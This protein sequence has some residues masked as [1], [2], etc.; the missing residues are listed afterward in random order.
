MTTCD[1]AGRPQLILRSARRTFALRLDGPTRIGRT[2]AADVQVPHASVSTWHAEL[3]DLVIGG[4]VAGA[5]LGDA[6]SKWELCGAGEADTKGGDTVREPPVAILRDLGSMNGTFADGE[7]Q[8][9]TRVPPEGALLRLGDY[10]RFGFCPHI[11]RLETAFYEEPSVPDN[12]LTC[13]G[14][15]GR[16]DL[17]RQML[18]TAEENYFAWLTQVRDEYISSRELI[19][20][21]GESRIA[22]CPSLQQLQETCQSFFPRPLSRCTSGASR[23]GAGAFRPGSVLGPP[24]RDE[25]EEEDEDEEEEKGDDHSGKAKQRHP[26]ATEIEQEVERLS[27]RSWEVVSV[28]RQTINSEADLV[29]LRQNLQRAHRFVTEELPSAALACGVGVIGLVFQALLARSG[30]PTPGH[31]MRDRISAVDLGVVPHADSLITGAVDLCGLLRVKIEDDADLALA[32][33][34]LEDSAQFLD[35]LTQCARWRG[36]TDWELFAECNDA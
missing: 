7:R 25:S 10:I 13:A 18:Q 15:D 28:M 26:P 19:G 16:M 3:E 22:D 6:G 17:R 32:R 23:T 11:H 5:D 4:G 12:A 35:D 21:A 8:P 1:Q 31:A 20:A 30:R 33:T 34:V 14:F 24:P 27:G 9:S 29:L 36:I 2:D